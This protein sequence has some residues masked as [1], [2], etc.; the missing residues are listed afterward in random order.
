MK[1]KKKFLSKFLLTTLAVMSTPISAYGFSPPSYIFGSQSTQNHVHILE[2]TP[3]Q[4]SS[5]PLALDRY[6]RPI[7]VATSV[8]SYN[9]QY[10][11]GSP[12]TR[13]NENQGERIGTLQVSRLN[14]TIGVFEGETLRNMDFG[15][16]RF[17]FSGFNYGNTALIGHN[18][19][20]TNGFFDFVR[21]LQPG[22]TVTLE[23][24]G[25]TRT[26]T[27][28]H[29]IIVHETDFSPLIHFGDDRLTLVTCVE[30]RPRYRRMAIAIAN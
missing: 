18:R 8:N 22:D 20:R 5:Q 2:R 13:A 21:Q 19:G 24:H 6:G 1:F 29:E 3:N 28:S 23:L 27:V 11:T 7:G 26:Y 14:R 15:A 9:H 25:V 10:N 17:S 4:T 16:G 30:Y 12:T